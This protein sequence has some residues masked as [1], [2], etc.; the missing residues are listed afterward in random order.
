MRITIGVER[1]RFIK[2]QNGQIVPAIGMLLPAVLKKA[3]TIGLPANLFTYELFGGQIEDRTLPCASLKDLTKALRDN[4]R[5]LEDAAQK[6]GLTFC[7]DEFVEEGRLGHLKANPF[8]ERHR[9]LWEA[10]TLERRLAASQ[11]AAV[12]V[13][14]STNGKTPYRLIGV[15][16][17][18]VIDEL[19]RL[20]DHSQGQRMRAYRLM[21]QE[22]SYPPRFLSMKELLAY[23]ET[24][25]GEKNVW[26]LVRYKPSTKTV[27]FRMFGATSNLTEILGYVRACLKLLK[28]CA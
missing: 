7:Y 22:S 4:D 5:V 12:H 15:C 10:L 19:I 20:G 2:D 9:T 26:D 8:D 25:G 13:H 6:C 27:E 1:E 23:I 11:V 28:S 17:K 14:L 3:K 16:T 21:T 18:K 24:K